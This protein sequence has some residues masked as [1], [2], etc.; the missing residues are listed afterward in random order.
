MDKKTPKKVFILQ[1]GKYIEITFSEYCRRAEI[2]ETYN[3]MLFLPLYGM[4][5]E[6]TPMTYEEFYREEH[7]QKYLKRLSVK[8]NDLSYDLLSNDEFNGEDI[9]IDESQSVCEKAIE[10]ILIEQLR[11][12]I[13]KLSAEEKNLIV[14]H[15]FDETPQTVLS[16][17]YGVSQQAMNQKIA[18][19]VKK[20]RKLIEN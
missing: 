18:K 15:F 7:R 9:L 20:L 2:D 6:V 1:N 5:M 19:I 17:L 13:Q 12:S 10:N 16:Q 11:L 14:A 4:L 8:N 3:R